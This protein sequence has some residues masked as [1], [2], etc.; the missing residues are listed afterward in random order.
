MVRLV[1]QSSSWLFRNI[2]VHWLPLVFPLQSR[3]SRRDR[4]LECGPPDK[5]ERY[6]DLLA[7]DNV[8]TWASCNGSAKIGF[9]SCNGSAKIVRQPPCEIS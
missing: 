4:E 1:V 5:G 3:E 9:F 6:G 7:T 8:E 2:H